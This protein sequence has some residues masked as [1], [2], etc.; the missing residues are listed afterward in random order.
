MISFV[1]AL[2]LVPPDAP[3]PGRFEYKSNQ[4]ATY[5][6]TLSYVGET[7]KEGSE[8]VWTWTVTE[9]NEIGQAKFSLTRKLVALS[10]EGTRYPA[11][12]EDPT[13]NTEW[14]S[15]RG[16]VR[17]RTKTGPDP[18]TDGRLLRWLD[19]HWPG[20]P[21]VP[22]EVWEWGWEADFLPAIRLGGVVGGSEQGLLLRTSFWETTQPQ[23][24][25]TVSRAWLRD[26]PPSEFPARIDLKVEGA[27]RPGDEERMPMSLTGTWVRR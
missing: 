23:A 24:E 18:A 15:P 11:S 16:D 27:V 17:E 2:A 22:G 12:G 21:V 25:G 26:E 14:R 1:L 3:W 5:D 13:V 20:G 8:E 4:S 7:E 10:V 9:V 19:V 6:V